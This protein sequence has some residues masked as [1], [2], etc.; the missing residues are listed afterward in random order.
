MEN[1]AHTVYSCHID[2]TKKKK[3]MPFLSTSC[4][5]MPNSLYFCAPLPPTPSDHTTRTATMHLCVVQTDQEVIQQL[6]GLSVHRCPHVHQ[7]NFTLP[8]LCSALV[9]D[10]C[11]LMRLLLPPLLYTPSILQHHLHLIIHL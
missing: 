10:S 11:Q 6:P 1:C 4:N 2:S 3:N 9:Y 7:V 5:V 8:E